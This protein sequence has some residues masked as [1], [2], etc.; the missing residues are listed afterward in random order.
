MHVK[1]RECRGLCKVYARKWKDERSLLPQQAQEDNEREDNQ[2]Q[3]LFA[4]FLIFLQTAPRVI[5]HHCCSSIHAN[6]MLRTVRIAEAP[7]PPP[8]QKPVFILPLTPASLAVCSLKTHS[9]VVLCCGCMYMT[10]ERDIQL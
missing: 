4:S 8:L 5:L 7:P 6:V 9:V 2:T 10:L 3:T 1:G